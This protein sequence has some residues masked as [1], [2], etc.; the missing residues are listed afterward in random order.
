MGTADSMELFTLSSGKHPRNQSQMQMHTFSVNKPIE[1][2][3]ITFRF[4]YVAF[5]NVANQIYQCGRTIHKEWLI[6]EH[7][8]SI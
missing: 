1:M 2:A 6:Q 4:I 5:G 3:P 7:L 8:I